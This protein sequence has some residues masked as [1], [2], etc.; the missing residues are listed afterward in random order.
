MNKYFILALLSFAASFSGRGQSTDLARIE[1]TYFPQSDSDNSFRR[2][3]SFVNFPIKIGTAEDSYLVPGIE[4]ENINFKYKDITPFEKGAELDRFQSFT[5]SLNYTY[6]MNPNWRFAAQGGL[7][8]AS[9]FEK[10]T[11]LKDDLLYIG[12]FFFIKEKGED[13]V[14]K[15]WRWILGLHYSTTSGMPFPLPIVNY[16]REFRPNW[17]YMAGVPKSNLKYYISLKT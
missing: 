5:L 15:S 12:S 8:M 13:E 6:K 4:Y 16:Y 9:N 10:G 1:Y 14:E 2:F 11:V 3:R 17:S 7:M